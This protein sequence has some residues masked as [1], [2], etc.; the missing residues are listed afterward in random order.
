[1]N[2]RRTSGFRSI[3]SKRRGRA[4]N[5]TAKG[6]STRQAISSENFKEAIEKEK[7]SGFADFK[8]PFLKLDFAKAGQLK[9]WSAAAGG[10]SLGRRGSGNATGELKLQDGRVSGKASQPRDSEGMFPTAFDV[11]FDVALLRAGE[12]LQVTVKKKP[13]PAA[14]VKPSVTGVCKGNG[15][16]AKLNYVSARWAEPNS[17]FRNWFSSLSFSTSVLNWRLCSRAFRSSK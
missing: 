16:E 9:F 2:S 6:L 1:M 11:R 17:F 12:S 13:G 4:P 8:R 14:N 10:T 3:R 15:K 7:D 5:R